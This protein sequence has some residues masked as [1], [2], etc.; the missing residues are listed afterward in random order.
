M[1][2]KMQVH[3]K[4]YKPKKNIQHPEK[5]KVNNNQSVSINQRPKHAIKTPNRLNL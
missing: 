3:L 4:P 5:S 1:Y 2:R